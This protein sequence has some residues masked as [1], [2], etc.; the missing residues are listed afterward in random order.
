MKKSYL[1]VESEPAYAN[2]LVSALSQVGTLHVV[3]SA[4]AA[5]DWLDDPKHKADAIVTEL[6]LGDRSGVEIIHELRSHYDWLDLPVIIH[7]RAYLDGDI[8][9]SD[10]RESYGVIAV[11]PKG[12][13]ALTKLKDAMTASRA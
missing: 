12:V 5:I 6:L 13:S 7:S 8:A 3:D 10:W 1:I 9:R 4:Q 2:L 11:I